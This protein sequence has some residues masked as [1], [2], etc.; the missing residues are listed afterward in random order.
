MSDSHRSIAAIVLAAGGSTRMG[1]PKQLLS[2]QG[3]TLIEHAIQR[4]IDSGCEQVYVV[5]GAAASRIVPVVSSF[6]AH[7]VENI[8]WQDG[9]SSSIRTG[10]EAAI[11]AGERLSGVLITL[12]DQPLV[13]STT[14]RTLIETF[15]KA[16]DLAV[17]SE[18]AGGPGV[19]AVFS[20]DLFAELLSLR[21]PEGAKKLL[22]HHRERVVLLPVP[23]AAID[24]DVPADYESLLA[25]TCDGRNVG[26]NGNEVNV[27]QPRLDEG[28]GYDDAQDQ[29]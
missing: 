9:M 18:Y 8:C 16:T 26:R 1:E 3:C 21:G 27:R 13:S 29:R 20:H 15:Q 12:V 19:P 28:R 24:V 7:V 23:E 25:R 2:Y 17:A 22:V 5:V 11:A 4:A 10:L 14:L 6:R